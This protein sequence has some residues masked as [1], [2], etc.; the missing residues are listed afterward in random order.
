MNEQNRWDFSQCENM[1][2]KSLSEFWEPISNLNFNVVK[3][4]I[5]KNVQLVKQCIHKLEL[6]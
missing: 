1:D 6:L 2:K 3:N 5:T 4:T